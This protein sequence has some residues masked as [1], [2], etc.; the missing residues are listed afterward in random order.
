MW[1]M[2]K[3]TLIYW[4]LTFSVFW[5]MSGQEQGSFVHEIFG[6][7]ANREKHSIT[8]EDQRSGVLITE[9]E[10]KTIVKM[11]IKRRT[12]TAGGMYDYFRFAGMKRIIKDS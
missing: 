11:G 4:A 10:F 8:K 6:I 2:I 9:W 1:Y 7:N 3:M 12:K 5:M